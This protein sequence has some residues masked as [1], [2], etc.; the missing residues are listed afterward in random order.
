MSRFITR[1]GLLDI[2]RHIRTLGLILPL[3]ET[4]SSKSQDDPPLLDWLS[5][6]NHLAA[7]PNLDNLT[8]VVHITTT[9]PTIFP[10][11][12]EL[13][14]HMRDIIHT[15]DSILPSVRVMMPL[16][17][18]RRVKRLVVHLEAP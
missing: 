13:L 11:D 1:Y 18:L 7:H 6:I 8:L 14:G 3:Y 15:K 17:A 2:L 12:I 4:L 9:Y 16:I 10:G 5:A